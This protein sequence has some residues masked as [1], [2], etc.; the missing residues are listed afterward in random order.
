M[1]KRI[2]GAVVG[3]LLLGVAAP[4]L[5]LTFGAF[6]SEALPFAAG[7]GAPLGVA[8]GARWPGAF[9]NVFFHVWQP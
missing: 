8:L 6:E 9:V 5:L 2:L 1:G 3:G 4:L 7:V